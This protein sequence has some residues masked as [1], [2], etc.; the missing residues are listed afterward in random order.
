MAEEEFEAINWGGIMIWTVS[1]K[2]I[3]VRINDLNLLIDRRRE[4]ASIY[5][6]NLRE[7]EKN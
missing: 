2:F 5:D 6:D 3:I 7:L 1:S 4:L